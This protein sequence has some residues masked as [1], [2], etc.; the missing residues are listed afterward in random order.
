METPRKPRW[1]RRIALAAGASFIVGGGAIMLGPAAPWIVDHVAD[2]QRV[3]RLGRI[4]IDGVTGSWL[5]NLRAAHVR[6]A[7]D[8]GVWI[9]AEDV[10]LNWE[11]Q[12]ILA[13][14]VNLHSASA[15]RIAIARQPVLSEKRPSSGASFNVRLTGVKVDRIDLAEA[16]V[17]EAAQ[18]GA[19][20]ELDLHGD[21]LRLLTLQLVRVDSD[22]D[23]ANILYRP[24]GDYALDAEIVSAPGGVLARL[25][26]VGEQGFSAR[27][28]GEGDTQ[29]GRAVYS[30][31]IGAESL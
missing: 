13:G 10:A 31:T 11:P 5:G 12:A 20:F 7:D 17:G 25:L 29:T 24:D 27:A 21:D 3:W 16:V 22:A 15:A 2:G 14:D 18:F 30:A 19:G 9:E 8:E 6:I 28:L 1:R 4:E 23:R 26:G